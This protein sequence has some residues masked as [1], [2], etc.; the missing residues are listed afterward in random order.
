M[1]RTGGLVSERAALLATKTKIDLKDDFSVQRMEASDIGSDPG[2]L[3]DEVQSISLFGGDR[4]IWVRNAG[5]E[6]GLMDAVSALAGMDMGSSHIL[7]RSRRPEEGRRLAQ[8]RR[9]L[10]IRSGCPLLFR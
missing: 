2:R 5:N 6:R 4:L 3:I 8:D 9:G 10:Q 7:H 1:V